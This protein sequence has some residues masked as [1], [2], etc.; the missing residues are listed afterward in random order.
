MKNIILTVSCFL[1]LGTFSSCNG[2]P[3]KQATMSEQINFSWSA[4]L[5][6]PFDFP[7]ELQ[8]GYFATHTDFI[9]GLV[10]N[11]VEGSGWQAE[12]T[13]SG[14]GGHGVPSRLSLTWVSY[15]E[16]KF[17]TIDTV[18]DSAGMLALFQK[19]FDY[20]DRLH[21][22]KH[23][24]YDKIIV[25][26]AP[27]GVVVVWVAG[28][29]HRAEVGRYQAKEARVAVNDFV[30]VVG[31]YKD[32]QEFFDQSFKDAL[33]PESQALVKKNGIPYGLW[34]EYRKKYNYRFAFQ[35]YKE[36][37]DSGG[38]I[39]YL[40][41]EGTIRLAKDVNTYVLNAPP[42]KA[43]FYFNQKWA[44]AFFEDAEIRNAFEQIT[45]DNKQQPVEVIGKVDFIYKDIAF[46][47][48]S[49]NKEIP[50]PKTRVK[51]Y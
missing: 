9:T 13:T 20:T 3:K 35:F 49:G 40:N 21:A 43:N 1:I 33:E 19:G 36:D 45:Q 23:I 42:L 2:Q 18:I 44:E 41:G 34:D 51:L 31:A 26:L 12:G 30:P 15:A 24:T 38:E 28:N 17:W 46:K 25:G 16:K 47:L 48:K 4:C 6:A 29:F 14:M 5:T 11:G 32:D 22:T 10:N 8:K 50:L 37:Q 7:V 39:T 27:G